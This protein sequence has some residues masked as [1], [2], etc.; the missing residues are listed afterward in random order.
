MPPSEQR[1]NHSA[2][3]PAF[4]PLTAGVSPRFKRSLQC[5]ALA[6][7]SMPAHALYQE[8]QLAG[9]IAAAPGYSF[10]TAQYR[11]YTNEA[12]LKKDFV[13]FEYVWL[14]GFR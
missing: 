11:L 12:L 2:L 5:I 7:I 10:A 4:S 3:P 8:Y 9:S 13:A 6:F 1:T 14:C